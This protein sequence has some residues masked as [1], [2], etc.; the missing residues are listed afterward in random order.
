MV[1]NNEFGKATVADVTYEYTLEDTRGRK[2]TKF[3]T[4]RLVYRGPAKFAKAEAVAA[5]PEWDV[6]SIEII[7]NGKLKMGLGR[8]SDAQLANMLKQLVGQK[9]CRAKGR[10][11]LCQ[12]LSDEL[13]GRESPILIER[14]Q[15][16]P[17]VA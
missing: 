15:K 8:M 17:C 2:E 14:G 6:V 12:A 16:A 13:S 1:K 3:S 10:K 4:L 7:P 5:H 9:A 11:A